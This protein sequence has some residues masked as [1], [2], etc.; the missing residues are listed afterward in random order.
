MTGVALS[1]VSIA[2]VDALR[3][4]YGER[5]A[6]RWFTEGERAFCD[7]R[8]LSSQHYAARLAAKFAVTR[9]LGPVRLASI[10]IA[11]DAAGAPHLALHAPAAARLAGGRL[12]VS[13]SHDG[14]LAVA[15]VV[16]EDQ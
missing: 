11:R 16:G 14:G 5:F 6:A 15:L 8:R 12:H 10:E 7:E 2:R 1:T 9:L 13:L 3:R 4:R